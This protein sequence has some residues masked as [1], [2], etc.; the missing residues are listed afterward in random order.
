MKQVLR[1]LL[2]LIFAIGVLT[3]LSICA[4]A[5]EA[6]E[7]TPETTVTGSGFEDLLFLTDGK[8]KTHRTSEDTASITLENPQGM[9][10]IYILFDLEYGAYTITDNTTGTV[11]TAGTQ[12][13]LHEYV[14]LQAAFGTLPTSITLAFA[15]G[16]VRLSEIDIYGVGDLPDS[17]Q[18]WDAPLEGKADMVLF[19]AHGD[20]DHLFFAGLMPYYGQEL[21]YNIQVVYMTDHRNYGNGRAHEML[22]GLWSVGIRAYPVFGRYADFRI[23]ALQASYDYY[24]SKYG[25][26]RDDLLNFVV[27]QVRR[28]RPLVTVTHDVYGEYGHGMH[29]I[30]ADLVMEATTAAN[31]PA[32]FPESAER[33]GTWQM[34]KVY[35]HLYKTDPIV[36][37]YDQPLES[38]GGMTAFEVSQK[39]GFPCHESQLYTMFGP[40]L[41]GEEDEEPITKA[42]QIKTNNPCKFGLFYSAVGAD[43]EKNDFFENV[44]SYAQQEQLEQERLEQERLEQERLEKERQEQERLEQERLERERLERERLEQERLEQER[45]AQEL[46]RK[47]ILTYTLIGAAV[48]LIPTLLVILLLVL[49]IKKKKKSVT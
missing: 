40:W 23:D 49:I 14:D 35:L 13:Y 5:E 12:E 45:L 1:T 4:S 33:Y 20:D 6:P 24:E 17:V 11:Y 31:D 39:I 27:T 44:L 48:I 25:V 42:T 26:T 30:Y 10:G 19:A 47:K 15:N 22:N 36:L 18:R 41:Y 37:N 43:V 32:I 28:F 46:R 3:C 16:A 34:Q 7:L 9:A 2:C 29:R 21:G 38:F 8:I